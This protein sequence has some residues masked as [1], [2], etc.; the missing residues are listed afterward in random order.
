[1]RIDRYIAVGLLGA[2][3]IG[4]STLVGAAA[5]TIVPTAGQIDDGEARLTYARLL[6]QRRET[7]RGAVVAYER[8]LRDDPANGAAL[9]EL[10]D[11]RVRLG[12]LASAEPPLRQALARRADDPGALA[13]LVRLLLWTNRAREAEATLVAA[14]R[15]RE[16]TRDERTLQ[17]QIFAQLGRLG[18]ARR[19]FDALLAAETNPS[20][21]LWSAAADVRLAGGE[22][23]EAAE[24]YRR[25][26]AVDATLAGARRGYALALAWS[27]DH[28]TARPRLDE[29][30]GAGAADGD[31]IHAW[32]TAVDHLDGTSA[33]IAQAKA[34][35]EAAPR[36]PQWRAEW[37]ELET[38]RGHAVLARELFAQ[39]LAVTD[40]PELRLR[41][42][43]AA[44]TWGDFHGAEKALRES[45]RL[46]P[47]DVRTRDELGRLLI[48]AD[49]L[50]EA[51]QFYERWAYET[52]GADVALLGLVRVRLKEKDFSAALARCD[53]LL[54]LRPEH[55][56]ALR[57]KAEALAALH[58]DRDAAEVWENLARR[59][60][61]R[62]DSEIALGR[63]AGRL[64]NRSGAEKY[65]GA[66]LALAPQRPAARFFATG[67]MGVRSDEFF[68][69]IVAVVENRDRGVTPERAGPLMEWAGLYAESGDFG[70]AVR[71]LQA[72]RTVDPDYFPAWA[73]L[74]EF[75]AIEAQFDAS[76]AE[77]AA[78]K[79]AMPGN[80][81]VLLGEARTLAWS[82][83]YEKALAAYAA[84]TALDPADPVPRREAART[85]GWAKERS[86][87]AGLY[88]SA[89]ESRPVDRRLVELLPAVIEGAFNSELTE[90]WRRWL[91]SPRFADEPFAW[92]ER[93][94]GDRFQLRAALPAAR[95]ARL[96]DIY[97]ELLPA[98]RIQRAWWL[99]NSAKQLAW[100]RHYTGAAAVFRRLIAVEPGN[101]EALFDLSQVQAAQ[102]LGAAEHE[103][104]T[105]LL[106]LDANHSLANHA[107]RRRELRS[108]PVA[109]V[110]ARSWRERGHEELASLRRMWI[111]GE[112]QDTFGDQ[113][114]IRIGGQLGRE[115]PLT[116]SGSYAFHSLS[117]DIAGAVNA[118]LSGSAGLLHREF[119][120]GRIGHADSGQAQLWVKRDSNALGIGYEKREELANE[121]ALFQGTRSDNVWLGG[122]AALTRRLDV[123]GR[124]TTSRFSDDNAGVSVLLQPAYAW[125]DHPRVL[126]TTLTLEYRDTQAASIYGR[127]GGRSASLVHPYWTPQDYLHGALTLEW[128]HDLAR[129][130]FVG[131]EE[132]F[133][134]L[135][136]T[137]GTDSESNTATTF[138]GDWHHEWANRWLVHASTYLSFSREWEAV[139]M[140]LR[141]ARRF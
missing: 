101:E 56:E 46:N 85:A 68:G 47:Q 128:F 59:P 95:R 114:N 22:V 16:L 103:T 48:S 99:E 113:T 82:R 112:L 86:Q 80:R 21:E 38:R 44:I 123:T 5:A 4:A 31:V 84:L 10:A 138:E 94:A 42:G 122:A 18:E 15:L 91:E 50:E 120:D 17:A 39:A 23:A 75:L 11:M 25:A 73:Q 96:D 117:A 24:F 125:S 130:F 118:W 12:D 132:R 69:S 30:T 63:I 43:R 81:Q 126:K 2:L 26:L 100:D 70:R 27:G 32:L 40:A 66:A 14:G 115:M 88:A 36:D 102:G 106:A 141:L 83:R 127:T 134:D 37:A 124:L 107:F 41:A 78:L 53:A 67:L 62:I 74:A 135:R 111:G 64:K 136:L 52:P 45:L 121:F 72:A 33:A 140:R 57:L 133:Y 109:T 19:E 90:T 77:F 13:A 105:Q 1:M 55:A 9:T 58:R 116:R 61:Y 137:F 104:L 89:W 97:L 60:E 34:R 87:G 131:S 93:F 29:L 92:T 20:A 35:A 51:D 54:I 65:F 49:R 119:Y 3:A 7:W 98:L 79:Q 28:A 110:E 76:L 129:E 71:C 6:S 139:G 108:R 8:L